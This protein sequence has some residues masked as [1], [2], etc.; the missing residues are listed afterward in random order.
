MTVTVL[1]DH[2]ALLH[3]QTV[4][5]VKV[6]ESVQWGPQRVTMPVLKLQG[7]RRDKAAD[8]LR[9]EIRALAAVSAAARAGRLDS[10]T[11]FRTRRRA[12]V[13]ANGYAWNSR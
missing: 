9:Q 13:C 2:C 11:S 5:A 6:T 1:L 12:I 7:R 8:W 4:R 10:Y 3:G